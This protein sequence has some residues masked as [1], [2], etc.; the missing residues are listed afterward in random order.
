MVAYAPRHGDQEIPYRSVRRQMAAHPSA[1]AL[2]LSVEI[3]RLPKR[4]IPEKVA[5]RLAQEWSKEG[6]EAGLGGAAAAAARVSGSPAP[7]GRRAH[8]RM[9]GPKP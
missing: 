2:G 4:P 3:M 7:L 6:V 9:V 5:R 8:V 1:E